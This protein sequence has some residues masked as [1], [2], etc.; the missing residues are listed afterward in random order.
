MLHCS[1]NHYHSAH[2][3]N[4]YIEVCVEWIEMIVAFRYSLSIRTTSNRIYMESNKS[5][6]ICTCFTY[7]SINIGR[8]EAHF[9]F[10]KNKIQLENNIIFLIAAL[11]IR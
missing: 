1:L 7:N 3:R 8:N 2:Y 6:F 10:M 5:D 11:W 9:I 4:D